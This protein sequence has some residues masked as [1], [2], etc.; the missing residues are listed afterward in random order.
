MNEKLA[1]SPVIHVDG[2][3]LV[4]LAEMLLRASSTGG[5]VRLMIHDGGIKCAVHAI[6]ESSMWSPALGYV[7]ENYR[8]G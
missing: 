6:G 3:Q 5:F 7:G 2:R 1:Q 8:P 4:D